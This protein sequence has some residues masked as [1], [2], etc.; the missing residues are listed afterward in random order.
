MFYF[1]GKAQQQNSAITYDFIIHYIFFSL[2][3][4]ILC[5]KGKHMYIRSLLVAL[6]LPVLYVQNEFLNFFN[7]SQIE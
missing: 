7:H 6:A 4:S 1:L 2:D 5:S 3:S